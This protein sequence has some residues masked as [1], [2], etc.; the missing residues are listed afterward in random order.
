VVAISHGWT[1]ATAKVR[2]NETLDRLSL[3]WM[4]RVVCVSEGQAVKVR[5][6]R[7]PA[8]RVAVIRNA[9]DCPECPT[10]DPAYGRQLQAL[11]PR[12]MQRVVGAVGRL[13]PE[14]GFSVLVEAARRM[15]GVDPDVGFVLFG[16]GPLVPQLRVQVDALGLR[17]R[18]VLAGFRADATCFLP[19]LDLVVLPSFT[20]GLP[21]VLLEAL[22]AAVPVVATAVGGT[23]EVVEDGVSGYLVPARDP[24]ALAD[25]IA[26]ILASPDRAR[27]MGRR[28]RE[29][30]KAEFS[31]ARQGLEYQRLFERLTGGSA[32]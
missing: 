4:D 8:D 5:Q 12:P 18:F 13:S 6:A 21:V 17:E 26:A 22:V 11:F 28:G 15:A 32:A 20:E 23:P 1:A 19:H 16:D 7:V 24:A 29:R 2:L 25:R 10:S 31:L 14:K 9:I 30:V 27:A 3:R